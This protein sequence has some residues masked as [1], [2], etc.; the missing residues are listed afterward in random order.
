[1]PAAREFDGAA[2][3][4]TRLA[5]VFGGQDPPIRVAGRMARVAGTT[6]VRRFEF[7][8]KPLQVEL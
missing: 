6:A 5:G 2:G 3:R 1:V 8:G 7:S 4:G